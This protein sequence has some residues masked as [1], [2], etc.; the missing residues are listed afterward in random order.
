M[1]ERTNCFPIFSRYL[2]G[3]INIFLSH[4]GEEIHEWISCEK[5]RR[6]TDVLEGAAGTCK[7]AQ[8]MS[9]S[10]TRMG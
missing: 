1:L 5:W 7:G 3:Y 9:E 8:A 10:A 2:L 4:F 6:Q